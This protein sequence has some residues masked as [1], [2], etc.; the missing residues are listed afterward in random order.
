VF[1]V[2]SVDGLTPETGEAGGQPQITKVGAAWA[3]TTA[4]LTAVGNGHYY[5]ELTTTEFNTLGYFAIR[6][7]SAATAEFNMDGQV[8]AFDLATA[9]AQTGDSFA[10]I[11]ASGISLSAIP[12]LAG[13]TTLLARIIGTLASGTHVA[14]TG[15][16][17]ARLGA[18]TGASVSVDLAAVKTDSLNL[19]NRLGA[20]T[21]SGLNTVLGFFRAALRKDA[22]LTPSD[23]AGTF[24]NTTDSLE[25]LKDGGVAVGGDSAGVTTLLARVPG[26]VQPQTGDSFARLGAPVAASISADIATR[27]TPAQVK[28]QMTDAL[29]VDTYDEPGQEAPPAITNLQKK[30]SY[31]Y[32]FLRNK[33][34]QTSTESQIWND[35]ST[36]VDQK[37]TV[38]DTGL[39]FTRGKFGIGP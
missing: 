29:N 13:V 37:A 4:T 20:F 5:V 2:D 11:G 3:N 8:V 21:G 34:T 30:I 24:D 1:L 33:I 10:R 32:K 38:S 36:I 6:Y 23:I 25:A 15:D 9:I 39:V 19:V 17:F 14:Q 16:S 27:A 18:P 28:T 22:A 26:T 31:V 12:D 7:K 35:A